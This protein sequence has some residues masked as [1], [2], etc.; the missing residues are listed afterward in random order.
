MKKL[1]KND[2]KVLGYPKNAN[3]ENCA[4]SVVSLRSCRGAVGGPC[5][6]WSP[7]KKTLDENPSKRPPL[8]PMG[9]GIAGTPEERNRANWQFRLP[10]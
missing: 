10:H 1:T 4:F 7:D 8:A 2:L 9:G 3:C 5:Y 6:G